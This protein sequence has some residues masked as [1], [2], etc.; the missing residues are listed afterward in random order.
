[1]VSAG[2]GEIDTE[3][4]GVSTFVVLLDEAPS[5]IAAID[6]TLGFFLGRWTTGTSESMIFLVFL[7]V[8]FRFL[9][10]LTTLEVVTATFDFESIDTVLL[11]KSDVEEFLLSPMSAAGLASGVIWNFFSWTTGIVLP[12]A[13]RFKRKISMISITFSLQ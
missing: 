1:M 13:R 4:P 10:F 7:L 3:N 5:F 2:G 11:E 9:F 6:I 8:G 12:T